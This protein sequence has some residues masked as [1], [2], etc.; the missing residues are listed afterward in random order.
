M[1]TI[2]HARLDWASTATTTPD[3]LESLLH[4][5]TDHSPAGSLSRDGLTGSV[6][7]ALESSSLDDA[8]MQAL[9]V[10]RA[11]LEQ[12]VPTA[13]VVGVEVRD[14][15]ALDR[16]LE[17]PVFPDVVGYAEIAEIAGVSRQRAR[18]FTKVAGFPA[19]VIV[20]AQGPLMARA[21]VE[22]WLET[23]N[24]RPGRPATS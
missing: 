21:A 14:G 5:L 22:R 6:I 16:E 4:E 15:D 10:G 8:L 20:T 23:R 2:W 13:D 1:P 18:A 12:S 19:P 11:A 24:T 7:L 9:A 17:Q 3:A